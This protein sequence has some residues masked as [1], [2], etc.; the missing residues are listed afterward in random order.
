M[1]KINKKSEGFTLVELLV[2]IAIIGLLS[3]LS[4]VAL[5]NA[6]QKARDAVRVANI[7]QWQAALEL[8]YQDQ[9]AY[10]GTASSTPGGV[11]KSGGTIYMGMIPHNPTPWIDGA[12][13]AATTDFIYTSS[14]VSTYTI[15]YCLAGGAGG[16]SAGNHIATPATLSTTP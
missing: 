3:T 6:R 15:N 14:V 13:C 8:Y 10:P 9:G 4:I 12:S 2:V 5:N 16:L 11:L 7:Q 1:Y